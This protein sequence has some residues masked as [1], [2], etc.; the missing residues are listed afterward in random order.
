M[1]D[2]QER[3]RTWALKCFGLAIM[4]DIKER[5]NRFLEESLELVQSL[6]MSKADAIA[7]VNYVYDREAG[8]PYQ[9]IGGVIT[10]LNSLC[11]ATGNSLSIC[12]NAE[13]ERINTREI[14][15]KIRIKH[16]GKPRNSPLPGD[17]PNNH[18]DIVNEQSI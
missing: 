8:I 11:T 2:Y 17:Y 10:T 3:V 7:L 18:L 9:E 1:R 6:D 16:Y 15:N 13:L 14:I 12:A 4:M 5:S